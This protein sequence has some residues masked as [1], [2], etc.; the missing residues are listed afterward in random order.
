MT[1]RLARVASV[2]PK[3]HSADLV[4]VD[5][6][7]RQAAVQLM[8][9]SASTNTGSFDLTTPSSLKGGDKWSLTERTDRDMLAVVGTLGGRLVVLGF[10]PPQTSE[11][12]FAE[13]NF[14]V[15]RHASD[16]YSTLDDAGNFEMAFPNGLYVRIAEDPAHRDLTGQNVDGSWNTKRNKDRQLHVHVEQ[17]GGTAT[18]D[19]APSGQITVTSAAGLLIDTPETHITGHLSVDNG[20]TVLGDVTADDISLKN[21][22]TSGVQA[23]QQT[24]QKPIP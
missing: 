10:L 18:L 21:H 7:S 9:E 4:M 13:A 20:V 24:S 19:I 5:D 3:D 2:N 22:R 12:L 11:M 14:K 17:A 16:V 6:G 8:C 15:S 23:G 1:L